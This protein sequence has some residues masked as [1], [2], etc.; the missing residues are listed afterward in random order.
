M[1]SV[2]VCEQCRSA[3]H[4]FAFYMAEG[5]L[6]VDERS[7]AIEGAEKARGDGGGKDLQLCAAAVTLDS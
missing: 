2:H 7:T 5:E 6:S 3:H 4:N 1:S